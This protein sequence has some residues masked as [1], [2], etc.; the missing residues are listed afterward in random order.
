MTLVGSLQQAVRRSERDQTVSKERR[1]RLTAVVNRAMP[2]VLDA[3]GV[4]L[5]SGSAM[6]W[7]LIA[8]TAALGVGV[9]TLNRVHYGDR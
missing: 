1:R 9:L 2:V 3:T 8:G 6:M 7:N 5:L 4:I